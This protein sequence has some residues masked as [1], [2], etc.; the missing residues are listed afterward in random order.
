MVSEVISQIVENSGVTAAK[1]EKKAESSEYGRTIGSPSLSEEGKKYYEQLKKKYSNMDFILVSKD[2]KEQA[3]ASAA[4]YA[5]PVKMV[6]LIDEE[7]IER[8]ATDENFRKQYESIIS[9]A[10][11]QLSQIK[12]GLGASASSVK[13]FGMQVNDGGTASYFAVID[14]SLAAQK[15]RIEK[16]AEQKAEAKKKAAKEEQKE[17]LE[18][19]RTKRKEGAEDAEKLREGDSGDYITIT[20]NSIEEL[21][22]KIQDAIYYGM[23]DFVQTDTEKKIGQNIDFRG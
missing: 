19:Q 21:L 16:K 22:Q 3:K 18:E 6:V 14:K 23:S 11:N 12:E 8:M 13:G 10:T 20:A 7:K 9:G 15:E 4:Q 1:K 2:M 17:R 5:N